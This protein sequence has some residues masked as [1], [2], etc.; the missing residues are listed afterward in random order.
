M[1]YT[2]KTSGKSVRRHTKYIH[3][4]ISLKRTIK[5]ELFLWPGEMTGRIELRVGYGGTE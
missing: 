3:I 4:I 2:K 5:I 1:F